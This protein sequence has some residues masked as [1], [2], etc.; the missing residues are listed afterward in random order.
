MTVII[1]YGG[2]LQSVQNA[3]AMA[4]FPATVSSEPEKIGATGLV[5]PGVGAFGRAMENLCRD[6]LDRVVLERV[7]CGVRLLGICV[8]MQVD[9]SEEMNQLKVRRPHPLLDGVSSGDCVYFVHSYY[10]RP[11]NEEVVLAT[12]N[13]GVDFAAVVRQDNVFGLQFHPEKSSRVG[14]GVLANLGRPARC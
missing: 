4:G 11:Q 8:G 10:A 9:R 6:G 2:N 12:A 7:S 1:D 5:L 3:F 13:Y 14:P